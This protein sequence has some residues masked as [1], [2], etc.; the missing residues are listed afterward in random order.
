MRKAFVFLVMALVIGAMQSLLFVMHARSNRAA[1]THLQSR[2]YVVR[3]FGQAVKFRTVDNVFRETLGAD[4]NLRDHV[5]LVRAKSVKQLTNL[6]IKSIGSL[7]Y[8]RVLN[9]EGTECNDKDLE[10]LRHL[11]YLSKVDLSGTK[12][13]DMGVDAFVSHLPNL[14]VI[15]LERTAVTKGCVVE[16]RSRIPNAIVYT[17]LDTEN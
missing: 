3:Y 15:S 17:S 10:Q 14:N 11:T 1:A 5:Y 2:G 6:D 13:T 7:K 4:I 8:L 16:I 12:V 9:L